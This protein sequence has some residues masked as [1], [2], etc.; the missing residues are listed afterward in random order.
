MPSEPRT[1]RPR[2]VGPEREAAGRLA[3]Y[4]RDMASIVPVPRLTREE[5]F[6]ELHD[7]RQRAAGGDLPGALETVRG[8][9]AR[10]SEPH[11]AA[12]TVLAEADG[13]DDALERHV[14]AAPHDAQARTLQAHRAVHA[15]WT[16]RSHAAAEH[17]STE[18]LAAFQ[19]HLRRAE[20]QLMRLCAEDPANDYAWYL[21]LAGARGLQLDLSEARRRYERL[22]ALDPHHV[23]GQDQMLQTLC[24]TW[25]G[26]WDAVFGLVREVTAGAADGSVEWALVPRA[27]LERWLEESGGTDRAY[28]ARPEVVAEIEAAADRFLAAPCPAAFAWVEAHTDFAVA[29]G[30]AS[31]RG[32]SAAHF[33]A[34]GSALGAQTWSYASAHHEDL[35]RIRA[36][37]LAE[38]R[39]R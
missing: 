34:L 2:H 11:L 3:P 1:P 22:R 29:L 18:Q 35:D 4:D 16:I 6:P 20:Q 12:V 33:R 21:R 36:L 26:T 32:R 9:R 17:V 37:A 38:G 19:D 14:Q 8:Y 27:H 25:G 7:L 31:R 39:R 23:V 13:L 28:L 15:G 10:G 5:I 30:L 24:P